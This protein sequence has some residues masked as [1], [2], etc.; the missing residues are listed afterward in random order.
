MFRT[1]KMSRREFFSVERGKVGLHK[2]LSVP[3]SFSSIFC[4]L[5]VKAKFL[6]LNSYK[7]CSDTRRQEQ[8]DFHFAFS[9]KRVV[10]FTTECSKFDSFSS[11][12]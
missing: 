7:C 9:P 3:F 10:C 2:K 4:V 1:G 6:L 12:K 5:G 8:E 11:E